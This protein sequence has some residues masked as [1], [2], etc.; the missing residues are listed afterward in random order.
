MDRKKFDDIVIGV[1]AI[2]GINSTEVGVNE[3]I[4]LLPK[5]LED[6]NKT[7]EEGKG[8]II[9]LHQGFSEETGAGILT[10]REKATVIKGLS[11][12]LK[13]EEDKQ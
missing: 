10:E 8:A 11:I 1:C 5:A 13:N 3:A 6:W 9:R 7:S 4:K 12:L 2:V